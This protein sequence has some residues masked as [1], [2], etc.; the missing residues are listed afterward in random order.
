MS[1]TLE[2]LPKDVDL[3]ARER[4]FLWPDS[5]LELDQSVRRIN[6]QYPD[7]PEQRSK[8]F[9]I[10]WIQALY[11]PEFY[12]ESQMTKTESLSLLGRN[13]I[14]PLKAEPTKGTIR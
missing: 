14:D 8:K 5:R 11:V 13:A 1:D 9:L 10:H 4:K 3:D 7:F 2:V 12:S 6:Q